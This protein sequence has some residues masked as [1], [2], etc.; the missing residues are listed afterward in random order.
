[1]CPTGDGAAAVRAAGQPL[2][3]VQPAAAV[4]QA[5]DEN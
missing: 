4:A 3:A 2:T 1:M 5:Q